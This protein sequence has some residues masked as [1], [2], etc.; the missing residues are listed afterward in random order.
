[1]SDLS[2][3]DEVEL[4]DLENDAFL[5]S[6]GNTKRPPFRQHGIL[7]RWIPHR[8]WRFIEILSRLSSMFL[9]LILFVLAVSFAAYRHKDLITASEINPKSLALRE[10]LAKRLNGTSIPDFVLEYAPYVYLHKDDVYLPSDLAKHLENTHPTVDFKDVK[11][12]PDVWTLDNLNSL[13]DLGGHGGKNVFLSS[14]EDLTTRPDFLHGQAPDP[15]TYRTD[16]ATSCVVIVVDKGDGVIDAFY[17]YWYIFND[18]PAALGHQV[19]NHLG[20]WEHNMIRFRN[21]TPTAV[22]YSQHEF[23]LALTYPAVEKIGKRPV[24]Y[25]AK[26]SHANYAVPGNLDLHDT[27]TSLH[28]FPYS[29]PSSPALHSLII[30]RSLPSRFSHAKLLTNI[31]LSFSDGLI[32]AH[33]VYD[34]TSR[35]KLWDPSLS[36]YY[37]TYSVPNKTFTAAI[38]DT[39]VNYLYYQGRW[40]DDQLPLE[41]HGQ[42]DFHKF[43]KWVA[44]PLGP[45]FKDLDRRDVCLSGKECVVEDSL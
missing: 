28:N 35:G 19:G 22:W 42:E 40:G 14:K 10:E 23:G 27:S 33:I 41:Q 31:F 12:G 26:G 44:G 36:A 32:P 37:Y 20:D 3:H 7:T 45:W 25:S 21:G 6:E 1:M 13:N 15:L 39:P 30:P 2:D 5:P 34:R 24:S 8:I 9:I 18:G 11:G 17:M 29:F 43:M 4:G 38:N 16:N